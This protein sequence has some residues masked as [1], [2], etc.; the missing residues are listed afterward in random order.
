[1]VATIGSGRAGPVL[2][3]AYCSQP[4]MRRRPPGS[5]EAD[6]ASPMRVG[7]GGLEGGAL[8]ND[9]GAGVAPQRDQQLAGERDDQRAPPAGVLAAGALGIPPAQGGARLV[10]PPQPGELD[11]GLAQLRLSR[12]GDALVVDDRTA[13][14]RAR[15]E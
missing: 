15:R 14:P 8:G 1:M 11:H 5:G 9:A 12:L 2:S 13:L 10:A 3:A 6:R 7:S 4:A